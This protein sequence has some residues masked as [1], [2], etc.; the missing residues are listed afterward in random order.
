MLTNFS[1]GT[2]SPSSTRQGTERRIQAVASPWPCRSPS[3][4]RSRGERD[5]DVYHIDGKKGD[6][7]RVAVLASRFGSPLDAIITLHDSRR[8]MLDE[9]RRHRRRDPLRSGTRPDS[10]ERWDLFHFGDRR[11]RPRR[12]ELRLPAGGAERVGPPTLASHVESRYAFSM[13]DLTDEQSSRGGASRTRP[14]SSP[15]ER[16]AARRRCSPSAIVSHL[17]KGEASVGQIVAITFT[18][19]AAREMRD[20]IRNGSKL[21]KIGN[22]QTAPKHL[23]DLERAQITTIHSFCGNLLRQFAIPAGLDPGFEVLDDILSANLRADALTAALHGLLEDRGDKLAADVSARTRHL[24]R[25]SRCGGCGRFAPP[26][27]RSTRVGEVA[28]AKAPRH[29][30]RVDRS[31]PPRP[32]AEMGRIPR[33]VTEDGARPISVLEG[34]QGRERGGDEQGSAAARGAA[35]PRTRPR[36]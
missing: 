24:V 17:R 9:R 1:F 10:S 36:T 29:R 3:R 12:S 13:P 25:L 11:P 20:R 16:A 5:V 30:R 22:S 15:P 26:A 23:R 35:S 28:R 6:K 32:P 8:A 4:G 34:N 19:K 21:A 14:S 2:H 7:V 33:R 31:H 27:G 18:D